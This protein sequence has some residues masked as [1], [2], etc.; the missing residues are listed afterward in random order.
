MKEKRTYLRWGITAFV[1][2]A[3]FAVFYDTV[4]RNG[5]LL[6]FLQKLGSILTP[7]ICGFVMFYLLLPI[8]RAV[9]RLLARLAKT[10]KPWFRAVAIVL[11][12]LLVVLLF[13][14][15]FSILLPSL[16]DSVRQLADNAEG[17]YHTVV[18]WVNRQVKSNPEVA[19]WAIE[20]VQNYYNDLLS[21]VTDTWLPQAQQALIAVTGGIVSVLTFLKDFLVGIVI[22]VYL[23][24]TPERFAAQIKTLF[25]R[26][27]P[28]KTYAR[29]AV[30][31][32]TVDRVFSGFVRGKL[33]DSLII[34]VLCF[35][36]S[37]LFRFPYA[38][39]ISVIVGVTNIIPFF[40][41]FLGA[42]PSAFLILLIDPMKSLYFVLFILVLQQIDGN[43][44]GPR[45][46]GDSTGLPGF[47]VI[48]AILLGGGFFGIAGMFLGVPV[49]ACI[50][51][52]I[53]FFCRP[54][55]AEAPAEVPEPKKK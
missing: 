25:A 50:Y 19:A 40:G 55:K 7:I 15:F 18:A 32:R 4:F 46:L 8:V 42:I 5:V 48:V 52:S 44:I 47:W 16:I 6:L 41:P 53:A 22:S 11:T 21:W 9:E 28:P 23:L 37:L 27:F 24:A 2:A 26:I 51:R 12:W 38:P 20:T 34:G 29:L 10:P 45:I 31:G 54:R 1:T 43:V 3:A 33:L 39:L 14:G 49:F 17:Y 35:L 36:F 13:Y 30:E